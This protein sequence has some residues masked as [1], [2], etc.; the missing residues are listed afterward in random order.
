MEGSG[1]REGREAVVDTA[2][3]AVDRSEGAHEDKGRHSKVIVVLSLQMIIPCFCPLKSKLSS[4][5]QS[6][7]I[8]TRTSL[9]CFLHRWKA[10]ETGRG[11]S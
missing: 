4:R 11:G 6:P 3:D 5:F 7:K 9:L 8:P 10:L 1:D 2:D